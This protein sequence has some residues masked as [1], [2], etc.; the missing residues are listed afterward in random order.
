MYSDLRVYSY[1]FDATD[2]P[3]TREGGGGGGTR[4]SSLET[5]SPQRTP[6]ASRRATFGQNTLRHRGHLPQKLPEQG[7]AGIRLVEAGLHRGT[8]A[9]CSPYRAPKAARLLRSERVQTPRADCTCVVDGPGSQ[10]RAWSPPGIRLLRIPAMAPSRGDVRPS[11]MAYP[12]ERPL[13]KLP[14]PARLETRTTTTDT[15]QC[16]VGLTELIYRH[17][18]PTTPPR[19]VG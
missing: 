15:Y 3:D 7:A 11:P 12:A 5:S 10:A 6:T 9:A 8:G 19:A 17:R 1:I 4:A 2:T 14:L 13:P 16:H 18:P